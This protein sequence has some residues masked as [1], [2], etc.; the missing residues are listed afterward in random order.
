M[1]F[2]GFEEG[3]AGGGELGK[4]VQEQDGGPGVGFVEEGDDCAAWADAGEGE[5]ELRG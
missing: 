2:F 3:Y 5:D 1:G 4:G